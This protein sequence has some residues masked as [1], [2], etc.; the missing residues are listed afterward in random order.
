[1]KGRLKHLSYGNSAAGNSASP[2]NSVPAGNSESRTTSGKS[3]ENSAS[4]GNYK[5]SASAGNLKK[6]FDSLETKIQEAKINAEQAVAIKEW[7]QFLLDT[8]YKL[9]D[10]SF[11]YKLL[12]KIP[13]YSNL[14]SFSIFKEESYKLCEK[15]SS[16]LELPLKLKGCR[17][18]I[19][20]PKLSKDTKFIAAGTEGCVLKPALPNLNNDNNWK[21]YPNSVTKLYTKPF[22]IEKAIKD[23]ET[24]YD[25]LKNSTHQV[26]Q[27]KYKGYTGKNIPPAI[28]AKCGIDSATSIYPLRMPDL[29]TDIQH[30]QNHYREYRNIPVS[31]FLNQLLKV[32]KQVQTLQEKGYIHGDIRETNIMANPKTGVLTLID[33]GWLYPKEEFFKHYGDGLGFYNNPP[34]SLLFRDLHILLK[35]RNPETTIF[36]IF[37]SKR[38]IKFMD[39]VRNQN[40]LMFRQLNLTEPLNINSLTKTSMDNIIYLVSKLQNKGMPITIETM[41]NAFLDIEAHFFDSFG[42]GFSMLEFF[43]YV[44]FVAFSDPFTRESIQIFKTKY[45]NDGKAYSNEE[46]KLAVEILNRIVNYV[47]MPMIS[48]KIQER[49]D[50]HRATEILENYINSYESI[51]SSI[52]ENKDSKNIMKNKNKNKKN[53]TRSM[54]PEMQGG[55]HKTRRQKCRS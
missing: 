27:Y 46:S 3:S 50:I 1:M 42:L 10:T 52:N 22:Y 35:A 37:A 28:Q 19:T 33:F 14:S 13:E 11:R 17:G 55:S 47:L 15:L 7:Y 12:Q 16:L 31:V 21:E 53:T 45:T 48:L 8:G 2:E 6:Q 49:N 9:D 44:Y 5:N 51:V 24:I 26:H 41:E 23:S 25:L 30:I 54:E 4:P 18:V 40:R 43:Y 20:K 34:E 38:Y 39:Y 32:F 36:Q 29:G